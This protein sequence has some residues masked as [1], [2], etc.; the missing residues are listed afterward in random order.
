MSTSSRE[1]V[2]GV[3]ENTPAGKSEKLRVCDVLLSS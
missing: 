1:N 2:E 3:K